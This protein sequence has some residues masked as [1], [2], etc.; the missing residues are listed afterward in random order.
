MKAEIAEAVLERAGNYCEKCGKVGQDL[1]LHHRKL[2]SQGG[3]DAVENLI[4][5]H[6]ECHNMGTKAIH[7]NPKESIEN[8]WIVPSWAEPAEYP[9]ILPDG[10]RVLLTPEGSYT[11]TEGEN[12]GTDRSYW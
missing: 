11:S 6:H 10:S 1:A 2:K 8:G 4:A 3:Q 9:L 12:Y 5:V 7:M